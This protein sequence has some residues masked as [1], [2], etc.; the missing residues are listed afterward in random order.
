MSSSITQMT[1]VLRS[2]GSESVTYCIIHEAA[3]TVITKPYGNHAAALLPVPYSSN[4]EDLA[5]VKFSTT[6]LKANTR[7]TG[8][9]A[10]TLVEPVGL[11]A[12]VFPIHGGWI[13]I[14]GSTNDSLRVTYTAI[15]Q[16]SKVWTDA[17]PDPVIEARDN[18]TIKEN[19]T[20]STAIEDIFTIGLTFYSPR[21]SFLST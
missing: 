13:N 18:L 4:E 5:A 10:V 2:K 7:S 11:S 15:V 20:F 14:I 6:E 9:F 16:N 1:M 12:D 3:S 17:W 21:A 8:K 19:D